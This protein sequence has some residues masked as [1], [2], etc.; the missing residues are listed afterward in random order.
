MRTA[1]EAPGAIGSSNASVGLGYNCELEPL[2]NTVLQKEAST[3]LN[4]VEQGTRPSSEGSEQN[5]IDEC[6]S[7]MST[8][9]Y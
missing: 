3:S 8:Y 2:Q 1:L 6:E 9:L 5:Q 7:I 4:L